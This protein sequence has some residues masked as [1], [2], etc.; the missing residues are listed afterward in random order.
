MGRSARRAVLQPGT[1]VGSDDPRGF[2][3]MP[4]PCGQAQIRCRV[5]LSQGRRARPC[6][7]IR[8]LGKCT[9]RRLSCR[10]WRARGCHL[11]L[12]RRV[13]TGGGYTFLED[14]LTRGALEEDQHRHA[15]FLPDCPQTLARVGRR[16]YGAA[17]RRRPGL[18]GRN[19]RD[20]P[21]GCGPAVPRP[22][23]ARRPPPSALRPPPEPRTAPTQAMTLRRGA[24]QPLF[25]GSKGRFLDAE[26]A[27]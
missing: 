11:G 6:T 1:C 21:T 15:W 9:G 10:R 25:P 22:Q 4:G 24:A 27:L 13:E 17:G 3:P 12:T 8:S 2:R 20:G 14:F 16:R 23:A 7:A 19:W 5:N 26:A 18:G